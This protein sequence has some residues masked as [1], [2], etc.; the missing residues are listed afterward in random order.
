MKGLKSTKSYTKH[1]QS[2]GEKV[3]WGIKES[4]PPPNSKF[5]N[6]T[7]YNINQ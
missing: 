6:K 5:V 2:D 4:P 7:S 3:I 1:L